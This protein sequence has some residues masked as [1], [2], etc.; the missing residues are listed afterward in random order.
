MVENGADVNNTHNDG[1]L[2]PLHVAVNGFNRDVVEILIQA[3]CDA[4]LKVMS[5]LISMSR[6]K[7]ISNDRN[8]KTHLGIIVKIVLHF[9]Y[10]D[11]IRLDYRIPVRLFAYAYSTLKEI[12]FLPRIVIFQETLLFVSV[13]CSFSTCE[14]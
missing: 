4:N 1:H 9:F 7:M 14:R 10:R 5:I 8:K 11:F 3:G 6:T 13:N 2:A 12:L